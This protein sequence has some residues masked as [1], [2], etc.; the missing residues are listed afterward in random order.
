[1]RRFQL[2]LQEPIATQRFGRKVKFNLGANLGLE[3]VRVAV[4]SPKSHEANRPSQSISYQCDRFSSSRL[5]R[6]P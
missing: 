2:P 6:L 5:W 3:R 1:M 4:L